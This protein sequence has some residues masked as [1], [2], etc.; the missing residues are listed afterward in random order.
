MTATAAPSL[1]RLIAAHAQFI[2]EDLPR[3]VPCHEGTN[4]C[5]AE[6]DHGMIDRQTEDYIFLVDRDEIA[7]GRFTFQPSHRRCAEQ[8]WGEEHLVP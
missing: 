7:E 6:D 2:E 4:V 1:E 5:F 3:F 8:E